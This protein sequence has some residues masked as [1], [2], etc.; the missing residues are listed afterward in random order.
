[1]YNHH[2]TNYNNYNTMPIDTVPHASAVAASSAASTASSA[3]T[4][5]SVIINVG[6]SS[7]TGGM[8]SIACMMIYLPIIT[9]LNLVS[10]Y[11]TPNDHTPLWDFIWFE[12][13]MC[14]D[15]LILYIIIWYQVA[16]YRN[17]NASV[18]EPE[19]TIA[20][21]KKW[22]GDLVLYV[23]YYVYMCGQIVV[24]SY[25]LCATDTTGKY[26]MKWLVAVQITMTFLAL[27][28]VRIAVIL[29]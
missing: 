11:L 20:W 29:K 6:M 16:M 5:T 4:D 13:I 23:S 27:L 19:T 8:P 2:A 26:M 24:G 9:T 15:W 28:T 10:L 22:W 18:P 7:N 25:V 12:T 3:A 17:V 14:I 1:M 21:S